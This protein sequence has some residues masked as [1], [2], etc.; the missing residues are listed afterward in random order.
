MLSYS[1]LSFIFSSLQ[2][3]SNNEINYYILYH[4]L[5]R[6]RT[7]PIPILEPTQN[8]FILNSLIILN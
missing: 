8:Y 2:I 5:L 6:I 7:D 4:K 1:Q 3:I